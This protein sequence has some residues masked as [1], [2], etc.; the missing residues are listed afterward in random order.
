MRKGIPVPQSLHIGTMPSP[1]PD[2]FGDED[3]INER[4]FTDVLDD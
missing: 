1:V 2:I 4:G 3:S